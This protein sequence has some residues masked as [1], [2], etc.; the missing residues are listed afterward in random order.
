M[1]NACAD[2]TL[3]AYRML[4]GAIIRN[5]SSIHTVS[6]VH[7]AVIAA[8]EKGAPLK[9]LYKLI[10]CKEDARV[11]EVLGSDFMLGLCVEGTGLYAV[12][13]TFN[14]SCAPNL[15]LVSS[16]NCHD[17]QLLTLSPVRPVRFRCYPQTASLTP[18]TG[19]GVADLLHR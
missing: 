15:A 9:A 18:R 13:N 4:N 8:H 5:A 17:M 10:D 11:E 7:T 6:D 16:F 2:V 12:A 19:P 3:Q 14:H 1:L